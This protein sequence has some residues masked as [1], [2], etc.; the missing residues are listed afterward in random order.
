[1]RFVEAWST[2]V[3]SV[4]DRHKIANHLRNS[5]LM[6]FAMKVVTRVLAPRQCVGVV[7]VV[8][9]EAGQV[10]ILEHV[11]RTDFPWGLPGGWIERGEHPVDAVRR[12]IGEELRLNV[13]VKNLLL[14]QQIDLVAKSS[15]PP[16]LGLAYYCELLSGV[17]TTTPEILSADWV[18]PDRIEQELA[19][20]QREAIRLGRQIF[21]Q[22]TAAAP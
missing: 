8:F 9:N 5:R 17:L 22:A 21:K 12:E 18:D 13:R 7:G 16:H 2:A 10:L 6:V 11:F 3:L 15:H 20:F 14:S 1:M 19:P 4:V